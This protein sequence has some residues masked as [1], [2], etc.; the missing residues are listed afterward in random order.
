MP[1]TTIPKDPSAVLDYSLDWSSWLASGESLTCSYWTADSGITATTTTT[2]TSI[3]TVWLS[4]GTAGTSYNLKNTIG[5]SNSRID[6][7]TIVIKVL[8]R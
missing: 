3:S 1:L 2:T 4:G 6:E 7:R 8:N 5:T